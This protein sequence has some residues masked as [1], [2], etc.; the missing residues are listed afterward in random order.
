LLFV[1]PAR[2]PYGNWIVDWNVIY[3][4][5]IA[6][7]T[8]M[9]LIMW[10]C[11]WGVRCIQY[12]INT[13]SKLSTCFKNLHG[14]PRNQAWGRSL[15]CTVSFAI[16]FGLGTCPP[17]Q[18]VRRAY[19]LTVNSTNIEDPFSLATKIA[20]PCT[21]IVAALVERGYFPLCVGGPASKAIARLQDVMRIILLTVSRLLNCVLLRQVN[22]LA[23]LRRVLVPVRLGQSRC[24]AQYL[25]VNIVINNSK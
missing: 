25:F 4:C 3:H 17:A 22:S 19:C 12:H 23:L 1:Y 24:N 5:R 10:C 14:Y 18:E 9:N 11:R 2:V 8:C 7:M 13:T 6:L 15:S 20:N 16:S 21:F